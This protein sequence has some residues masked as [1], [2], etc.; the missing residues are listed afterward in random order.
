[1]DTI[2]DNVITLKE[3][4]DK[5]DEATHDFGYYT[6][7]DKG[8]DEVMDT[9]PIVEEVGKLTTKQAGNLLKKL[10][11]YEKKEGTGETLAEYILSRLD[12]MPDAW[13]EEVLKISG[14]TY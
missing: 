14:I 5:I 10:A 6:F 1:M 2:G 7:G 13:F 12:D 11:T 8:P 4:T 3:I 9:G